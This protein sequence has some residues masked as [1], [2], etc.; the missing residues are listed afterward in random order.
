MPNP[1]N[2]S[3]YNFEVKDIRPIFAILRFVLPSWILHQFDKKYVEYILK[4]IVLFYIFL[5]LFDGVEIVKSIITIDLKSKIFISNYFDDIISDSKHQLLTTA[6]LLAPLI[7]LYFKE[8]GSIID[9]FMSKYKQHTDD[10][11][12]IVS[13]SSV[14]DIEKDSYDKED[15]SC[16]ISKIFI[17]E[18]SL[19]RYYWITI[20][21]FWARIIGEKRRVSSNDARI[22]ILIIVSL[23]MLGMPLSLTDNESLYYKLSL[24]IFIFIMI[25]IVTQIFYS[26]RSILKLSLLNNATHGAYYFYEK[27]QSE[28]NP[29]FQN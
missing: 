3:T 18:R 7:A 22:K 17:N 28:E 13:Q 26:A 9:D 6:Y 24:S 16:R 10:T 27:S 5:P 29:F 1:Y 14:L 8:H 12:T 25:V 19:N 11:N 15:L 20:Y 21:L 2:K 4:I 23:L